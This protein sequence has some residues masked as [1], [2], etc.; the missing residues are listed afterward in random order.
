M[1]SHIKLTE[2]LHVAG[3]SGLWWGGREVALHDLIETAVPY[4]LGQLGEK[5]G[6]VSHQITVMSK[7][8]AAFAC[9][10]RQMSTLVLGVWNPAAVGIKFCTMLCFHYSVFISIIS[11]EIKIVEGVDCCLQK[12]LFILSVDHFS[13]SPRVLRFLACRAP[14]T[15]CGRCG[16]PSLGGCQSTRCRWG[17]PGWWKA[18]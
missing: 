18:T 15:G 4:I 14:W 10:Q 2:Y 5:Q 13:D 7:S 17:S 3:G 9:A 16:P 8:R 1:C 12:R 6:K 11:L